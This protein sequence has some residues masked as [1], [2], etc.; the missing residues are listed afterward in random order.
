MFL[1]E[2]YYWPKLFT[3]VNA[4]VRACNLCYLFAGKQNIPTL[5]L[6]PIKVEALFQQRGLDFIE[7]IHLQS[8]A[9]HRWILTTTNYFTKWVEAIPNQNAT[10]S[11]IQ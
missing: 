10:D 1:R 8:S 4:R 3:D 7:E 5:P 9:Q 11:V 2:G 6:I